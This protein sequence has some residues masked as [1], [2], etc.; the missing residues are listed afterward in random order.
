MLEVVAAMSS[1]DMLLLVSEGHLEVLPLSHQLLA[2]D[3][4]SNCL[5]TAS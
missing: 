1:L 4:C 5:A 2:F 3:Y